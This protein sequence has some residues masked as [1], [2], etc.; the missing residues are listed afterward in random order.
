MLSIYDFNTTPVVHILKQY[1]ISLKKI[2]WAFLGRTIN[3]TLEQEN[4]ALEIA[5]QNKKVDFVQNK[6]KHPKP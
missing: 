3:S 2:D 4:A 1:L 5:M 6:G